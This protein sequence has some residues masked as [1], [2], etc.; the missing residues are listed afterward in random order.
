M[1]SRAD[2]DL[3]TP[4]LNLF[5]GDHLASTRFAKA[6]A[7]GD[8][9]AAFDDAPPELQAEVG[10]LAL[11]ASQKKP[12]AR[13]DA[14]RALEPSDWPVQLRSA[15]HVLMAR[16]LLAQRPRP[17]LVHLHA[18]RQFLAADLPAEAHQAVLS[19]LACAPANALA[20][21]FAVAW[22]GKR[23]AAR[24][25]FHGGPGLPEV[26]VWMAAAEEDELGDDPA[27]ALVY[28]VLLGHLAA[29]ELDWAL[30]AHAAGALPQL[31]EVGDPRAFG[32]CL[33]AAERARLAG[34]VDVQLRA[35]ARRQMR[36]IAP[37]A[38]ERYMRRLRGE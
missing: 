17:P 8:L 29:E 31:P 35:D 7:A 28:A 3:A 20:W 15:W 13:L 27:W 38:F 37:L 4:Q 23:A 19:Q 25:A 11:A 26:A 2:P 32:D 12:A 22:E 24:C 33:V 9:G 5:H 16:T 36:R 21:Q 14:L 30:A 18:A 6:L 1:G 10:Q 34:D